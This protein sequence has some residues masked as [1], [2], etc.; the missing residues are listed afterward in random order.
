MIP[1]L[2]EYL[3]GTLRKFKLLVIVADAYLLMFKRSLYIDFES[4]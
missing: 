4:Y 1:W 2:A 3:I